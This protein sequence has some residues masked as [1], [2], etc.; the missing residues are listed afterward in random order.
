MTIGRHI[1][2]TIKCIVT[3]I[4]SMVLFMPS[5]WA[6]PIGVVRSLS[7]Q[8]AKGHWQLVDASGEARV[9]RHGV[10]CD[11]PISSE[12]ACNGKL[13]PIY[14]GMPLESGDRII[15][16]LVRLDIALQ[17]GELLQVA[18]GTDL[19]LEESS[20]TQTLGQIYLQL[21]RVFTV[22]FGTVEATVE[23][24]SLLVSGPD[25]VWVGVSD[26]QVRV[27]EGDEE[28]LVQ[29]G[30]QVSQTLVEQPESGERAAHSDSSTGL[31][32]IQGWSRTQRN[33]MMATTWL[34]GRP[35]LELSI[36]SGARDLEESVFHPGVNVEAGMV[37]FRNLGV[38]LGAGL[39]MG[40]DG[41]RAPASA[42][43]VW[44]AGRWS[45]AGGPVVELDRRTYL[46]NENNPESMG[47][48]KAVH[49]G[50]EGRVRGNVVISRRFRLL[51]ELRAAYTDELTTEVRLGLGV[52][53]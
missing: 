53:L 45:V 14:K 20:I 21:R 27:K 43:L 6:E 23:G 19:V 2:D 30:E 7:V 26:G 44:N 5:A 15:T 34:L 49:F 51:G 46:C 12:V 16:A 8:T 11:H 3:L 40:E 22:R 13:I 18:E 24:T 9:Q 38:S 47:W 41:Q 37:L 28:R 33:E 17:K 25:P 29:S 10:R 52:G 48:Y 39:A 32:E 42:N 1:S 4:L 31:E 35:R 50:A 36:M